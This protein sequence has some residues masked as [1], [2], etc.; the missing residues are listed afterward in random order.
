MLMSS[1]IDWIVWNFHYNRLRV[2]CKYRS[3]MYRPYQDD[4]LLLWLFPCFY[5]E[6]VLLDQL[7]IGNT[8]PRCISCWCRQTLRLWSKQPI[9]RSHNFFPNWPSIHL[10]HRGAFVVGK[11]ACV[12]SRNYFRSA[13]NP[14]AFNGVNID[15]G[16]KW[17]LNNWLDRYW[18]SQ[19]ILLDPRALTKDFSRHSAHCSLPEWQLCS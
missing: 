1:S 4:L 9:H 5:L 8:D 15:I 16:C 10:R 13:L 7:G 11:R 2:A 18:T 17:S 12:E 3:G 19:W 6:L 14:R